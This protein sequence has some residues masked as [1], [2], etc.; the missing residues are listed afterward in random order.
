MAAHV[1]SGESPKDTKRKDKIT[2]NFMI[3][4]SFVMRIRSLSTRNFLLA[5]KHRRA[6]F[7]KRLY[8]FV[9]VAAAA[10]DLL[11]VRFVF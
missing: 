4:V 2:P 10:G 7:Q 1:F 8:A 5:G 3:F 9:I 6:F 11:Q